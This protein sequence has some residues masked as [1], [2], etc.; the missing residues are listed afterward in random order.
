MDP[1]F[2]ERSER[3]MNAFPEVMAEVATIMEPTMRKAMAELFAINF[4]ASELGELDAFFSTAVGSKFARESYKMA[5]DP[6]I[7]SARHVV[8]AACLGHRQGA[9]GGDARGPGTADRE[10]WRADRVYRADA[11]PCRR[12]AGRSRHDTSARPFD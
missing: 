5:A 2:K 12:P 8:A 11:D 7:L 9:V 3:Q 6:R 1:A 4:E 10:G